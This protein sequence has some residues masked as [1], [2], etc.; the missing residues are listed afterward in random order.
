MGAIT[1][2]TREMCYPMGGVTP[3][4]LASRFRLSCS[5]VSATIILV[6]GEAETPDNMGCCDMNEYNIITVITIIVLVTAP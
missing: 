6:L 1:R 5:L 3:S 2:K 4:P